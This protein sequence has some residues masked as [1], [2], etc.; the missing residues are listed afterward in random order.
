VLRAADSVLAEFEMSQSRT[1]TVDVNRERPLEVALEWRTVGDVIRDLCREER[2]PPGAAIL[3][4]TTAADGWPTWDV[5]IAAAWP[6]DFQINADGSLSFARVARSHRSNGK[7]VF[8]LCNVPREQ[9]I[10][11][12]ATF[13]PQVVKDTTTLIGRDEVFTILRIARPSPRPH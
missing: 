9:R 11:V 3:G 2:G 4:R 8:Y 6:S 12:R 13:G 5:P 7:G 1:I 10:G